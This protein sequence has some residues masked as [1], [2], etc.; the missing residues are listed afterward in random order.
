MPDNL[1]QDELHQAREQVRLQPSDDKLRVHLFQLESQAGRWGKAREQLQVAAELNTNHQL[2]AQAYGFTLQA[3]A[4]RSDVFKGERVPTILGPQRAWLDYLLRGLKEASQGHSLAAT[5]LRAQAFDMAPAISG[6]LDGTP[7]EWIADADSRLGPVLEVYSQ[8]D[9]CWLPFESIVEMK[10]EAP[11]DLRD[12]VWLPTQLKLEGEGYRAVMLPVR[13]PLCAEHNLKEHLQSR[14]SSW[15]ACSDDDWI[16]H[17]VR[18]L[19]T[20]VKEVSIL[21]VRHIRLDHKRAA[22]EN[23]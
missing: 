5:E 13:Y 7:F 21:D 23:L 9:Y 4:I 3:E 11:V 22:E 15:T 18:V 8:G 20:D 6:H 12:L 17:G 19:T 10:V 14:L 16:G 1:L 2:L